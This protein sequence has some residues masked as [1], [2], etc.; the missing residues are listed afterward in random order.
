MPSSLACP[1][2]PPRRRGPVRAGVALAAILATALAPAAS[3]AQESGSR[4]AAPQVIRDTEVEE[5][6]HEE[7]DPVFIAAGLNPRELHFILVQDEFNAATTGG[8][9][10]IIG[11]KLIQETSN[12]NELIGVLA[13]EAGHAAGGHPIR[14]DMQR[15]GLTPMIISAGL[16]LLALAAGVPE[17]GLALLSS[18]PYFGALASIGYSR[19][20]EARADQAAAT[21]LDKAGMSGRGL[22]DFFERF[23]YEEV[24]SE[25]RRFR[26]FVDHPISA[27]RVELLRR[28]VQA[29]PHYKA[30]DPSV[31]LARHEIMKA[32]LKAFTEAPQTTFINVS[33]SDTSFPARY[34]RAI[35]Y[36]RALETDRA[37]K[38]IDGLIAD[39]PSDPYLYELK[40]QTLFESAQTAKAEAAYARAVELKPDA[41]L[42]RVLLAQAILGQ[43]DGHRADAAIPHLKRAL[44]LETD[45]PFAWQLLSQA[46]DAKG[47][48]GA[49]RLAA[50]EA[51]YAV[52][53]LKEARI[54]AI[55]AREALEK[56]TPEWRRATDIVLA[57][58][59]SANDLKLIADGT[60]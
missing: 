43:D 23:R 29:Q 20:Q 18:S 56:N 6:I 1:S 12:P 51:R 8:R 49:A 59:P 33:E 3:G 31:L 14:N 30:V 34:A 16:G 11:T 58:R 38:L 4:A 26:F 50:A 24:F 47:Q 19:E 25:V 35:A 27:E 42:L 5:I 37:L 21:Y 48:G 60:G 10:F 46:Y 57:S 7:A 32:K 36:Y 22:V 28:R 9:Q 45:N 17:A 40:G 41:S 39:Y 13:H 55:R 54:F 52:G 53:D 15:A 44:V 2:A